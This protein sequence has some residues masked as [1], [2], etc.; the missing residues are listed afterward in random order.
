MFKIG[1]IFEQE[2]TVTSE[3]YTCFIKL[4]NDRNPLHT[5]HEFAHEKGF[6]G[7]VMHGNILNA[8]I[9]YFVGECLP[10]KN[11]IIHSQG[12]QFKNPVYLN[13]V[14]NFKA[15]IVGYY[16]SVKA[17]E[18]KYS[19]KNSDSKVVAKGGIQIGLLQ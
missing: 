12:I 4:S 8:F 16:E 19:F 2:F 15:E 3:A 1:D 13:D 18:F 10:I 7:M 5:N 9:S 11:V 14:L 17:V 6:K